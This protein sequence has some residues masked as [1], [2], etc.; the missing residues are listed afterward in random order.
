[1]PQTTDDLI[2]DQDVTTGNPLHSYRSYS[3]QHI[4]LACV[5]SSIAETEFENISPDK[6]VPTAD[7]FGD[8]NRRARPQYINND[9][10]LPFVVVLNTA[11]DA[12][13]LIKS[14]NVT[15]TLGPPPNMGTIKET[16]TSMYAT[17]AFNSEGS[18]VIEEPAGIRFGE[19]LVKIAETLRADVSRIIFVLKTYFIGVTDQNKTEII[20]AVKPLPIF[21]TDIDMTITQVGSRYDIK[22]LPVVNGFANRNEVS[23]VGSSL[24]FTTGTTI[25]EAMAAMAARLN[26]EQQELA[27]TNK[28][29]QPIE[30]KIVVHEPYSTY[31]IV[32]PSANKDKTNAQLSANMNESITSIMQKVMQLSP[33]VQNELLSREDINPDAQEKKKRYVFKII[34]RPR[35][36]KG[37]FVIEYHIMRTAVFLLPQPTEEEKKKGPSGIEQARTRALAAIETEARA[38]NNLLV[39]NYIFTG[40]NID[41]LEFDMKLDMFTTYQA[42]YFEQN[43]VTAEAQQKPQSHTF[44]V[45]GNKDRYAQRVTTDYPSLQTLPKVPNN[46]PYNVEDAASYYQFSDYLRRAVSFTSVAADFTI[47]GDPRLYSGLL[48]TPLDF[49]GNVVNQSSSNSDTTSRVMTAW[50]TTPALIKIRVFMP[51]P[52]KIQK[53]TERFSAPF[54]YD[55]LFAIM[56]VTNIFGEDG[57]FTQKLETLQIPLSFDLPDSNAGAA[58]RAIAGASVEERENKDAEALMKAQETER[59]DIHDVDKH[60]STDSTLQEAQKELLRLAYELAFPSRMP[61]IILQSMVLQDS[62]AGQEQYRRIIGNIVTGA[63]KVDAERVQTL[64][65]TNLDLIPTSFP[66]KSVVERASRIGAFKNKQLFNIADLNS[67]RNQLRDDNTFNLRCAIKLFE[68]DLAGLKREFSQTSIQSQLSRDTLIGAS[69][70]VTERAI[71]LHGIPELYNAS[72][73][74]FRPYLEVVSLTAQQVLETPYVIH[75][76]G[77]FDSVNKFN[78]TELKGTAAQNVNRDLIR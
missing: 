71:I 77:W 46:P 16:A 11:I 70:L 9:T 17:Q 2:L 58:S 52:Q 40:R 24:K 31:P 35:S 56:Q 54:W 14:L 26:A 8:I 25:G 6:L 28:D 72:T 43:P 51:L 45:S 47:A 65:K 57:K 36:S 74:S 1:M 5:E 44:V 3:Y 75:I 61:T 76:K 12:E 30:Y 69:D 63:V 42:Y 41:I 22:F 29:L 39:Y 7:A 78:D 23:N 21:F 37:A 53:A 59:R 60:L 67:I 20:T 66:Q 38:V 19:L 18:M 55:G 27:K 50:G 49:V 33:T 62:N 4:L 13:F 64:L 10:T 68:Q 73:L 32:V 15:M 34:S 48:T